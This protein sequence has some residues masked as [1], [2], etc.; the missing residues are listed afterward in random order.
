M[1]GQTY[2]EGAQKL[3]NN[4]LKSNLINRKLK[5]PPKPKFKF[6][7]NTS[8]NNLSESNYMVELDEPP[9]PK[10][11]PKTSY[12]IIN[13]DCFKEMMNNCVASYGTDKFNNLLNYIT[14]GNNKIEGF[15]FCPKN[16]N[17]TIKYLII[18]AITVFIC[19]WMW[20]K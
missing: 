3:K 13:N 14:E 5:E 2:A 18:V 12:G 15:G 19:W 9:K 6:S 10:L 16:N 20:K 1:Y 4:F 7:N 17:E 8:E 11:I